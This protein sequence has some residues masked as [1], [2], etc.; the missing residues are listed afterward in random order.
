MLYNQGVEREYSNHRPNSTAFK[1]GFNETKNTNNFL[2]D[3]MMELIDCSNRVQ[4][5]KGSVHSLFYWHLHVFTI[6]LNYQKEP[7][8]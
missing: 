6:K 5:C 2:Q 3:S 4:N 8:R 1:G 7:K